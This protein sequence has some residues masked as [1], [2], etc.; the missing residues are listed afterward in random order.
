MNKLILII[1]ILFSLNATSQSSVVGEWLNDKTETPYFD[2]TGNLPFKAKLPDG[3]DAQI[4]EDPYFLMGNYKF[5]L[6]T[7]VSGQY[8]VFS[9]ERAASRFGKKGNT[10]AFIEIDG[11]NHD[12]IGVNS[13]AA[14]PSKVKRNFGLGYAEFRYKLGNIEVK[15]QLNVKPSSDINTGLS[16]VLISVTIRNNGKKKAKIKYTEQMLFA[17]EQLTV[18]NDKDFSYSSTPEISDN[19]IK[20]S[21]TPD[22]LETIFPPIKKNTPSY[23]EYFPPIFFCKSFSD[24][25]ELT[26]EDNLL[27]NSNSFKLGAN[28]E[29]TLNFIVG[30]S[31][32]SN[33]SEINEIIT[34]LGSST[35]QKQDVANHCIGLFTNEWSENVLSFENEKDKE[36]KNELI[37]HNYNLEVLATFSDFYKET[38]IPQA[39]M[40]FFSRGLRAA[41]RDHLQHGLAACYTNPELAKSIIRYTLKKTYTNGNIPFNERGY[42]ISTSKYYYTSDQELYLLMLMSEYLRITK[43]YEFLNEQVPYY[44]TKVTKSVLERVGECY[45][46]FK[47]EV[48]LGPNGLVLLRNSDW[49]DIIFYRMDTKYNASFDSNESHMNTTMLA[50]YFPK[51]ATQ[52][53]LASESKTLNGN[54]D[55]ALRF[56]NDMKAYSDKV[57]SNF[58]KDHG[59]RTFARRMY[60]SWSEIGKDNMFLEPQGFLMQNPEYPIERKKVLYQEIKDRILD[61]E[62]IGAR[63]EEKQEISKL[64]FG[65]R[66]NGGIWFSLNGP[67]V[68][69]LST[70]N[71]EA[72]WKLFRMQT[73]QNQ[74]KHF[75]NYWTS[76][77]NSFDS[78]DSSILPSEGLAA[79]RFGKDV[80][81]TYCSHIHAWL[82]YE[83]LYLTE[84]ENVS[85]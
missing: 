11:E 20:I 78:V 7:Y 64:Y 67:L 22:N 1:M 72:A 36:L 56:S 42:G 26:F 54:E 13:L 6:F 80:R 47:Y 81:T 24:E 41:P 83:Y 21:T 75:P 57:W 14:D 85:N 25:S 27:K 2:F 76:Y 74:A 52:L 58:L 59:D 12:L 33:D 4:D 50:S 9:G 31:S 77:W 40:Y 46:Y 29:V 71:K 66:E 15:R 19:L 37:W 5:K 10:N 63:Q 35:N 39:T 44:L 3:N 73:L 82:V 48:G 30:Y 62:T 17:Y 70:W 28:K 79:Q 38:F 34:D 55:Y 61:S 32:A 8:E 51:L 60:F 84:L 53:K 16:G 68:I 49:N 45:S 18:Q 65:S 43:D 23:E 69:G